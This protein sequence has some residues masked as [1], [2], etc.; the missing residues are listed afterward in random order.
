MAFTK[1]EGGGAVGGLPGWRVT[2]GVP[3][4]GTRGQQGAPFTAVDAYP[5]SGCR[6][7]KAG[8][9]PVIRGVRGYI[10]I[11]SQILFEKGGM[12]LL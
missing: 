8:Q 10:T 7:A 2:S 11:S 3:C 12:V 5:R 4:A 6:P 1:K 9:S